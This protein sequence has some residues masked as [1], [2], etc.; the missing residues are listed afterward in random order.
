VWVGVDAG[1]HAHHA[2]IMDAG[3]RVLWS[4]RIANDQ[5]AIRRACATAGEV[6]WAVDL[7]CASAALLLALLIS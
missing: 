2:V 6:R 3:G 4:G 7:T 5:A 1:K